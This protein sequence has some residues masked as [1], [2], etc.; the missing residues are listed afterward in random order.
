MYNV[1]NYCSKKKKPIKSKTKFQSLKVL[2]EMEMVLL[3]H[4][5]L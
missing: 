3:D 1:L 5:S 4:F 2:P